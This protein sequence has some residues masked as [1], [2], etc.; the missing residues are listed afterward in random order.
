MGPRRALGRCQFLAQRINIELP[1][2]ACNHQGGASTYDQ[3]YG[4]LAL[5]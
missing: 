3:P 4:A 2:P 1:F 5:P